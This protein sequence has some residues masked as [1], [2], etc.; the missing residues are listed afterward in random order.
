MAEGL[1]EEELAL[2][3][4]LTK[5]EPKLTRKQETVVKK[6]SRDLLETLK[7]EKLV[8]DWRNKQQTRAAVRTAIEKGLDL[9]PE[10]LYPKHLYDLKCELTYQHVYDVYYG[11]GESVYTASA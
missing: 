5:P 2:F 6:V 11:S 8:L 3:D 1:T 9:L 10:G 7:R 4:I